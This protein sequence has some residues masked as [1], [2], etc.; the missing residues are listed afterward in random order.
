MST[1]VETLLEILDLE[2]L[3]C[4]LFR[5]S[6]PQ[7]GWQRVFGGRVIGQA[8]VA[9]SRAVGEERTAH[10]MHGYFLRSGDP[11]VPIL[12]DVE[13]IR[14]GRSFTTRR[15][16]AIQHGE[17]IFSMAA[18]FHVAEQGLNIR[19]KCPRCRCRRI[20]PARRS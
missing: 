7:S 8:L 2:T 10:S 16:K 1:A 19:R 13:R 12:Y 20:C 4:N 18:S 11:S 17:A 9:A 14:D 5:R 6:N 3:E 15:V